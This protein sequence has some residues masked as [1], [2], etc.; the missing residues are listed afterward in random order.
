[1]PRD[2]NAE[3]VRIDELIRAKVGARVA[4]QDRLEAHVGRPGNHG[5]ADWDLAIPQVARDIEIHRAGC[6]K[7]Q[8]AADL[9]NA[10][11]FPLICK[12]SEKPASMEFRE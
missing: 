7:V 10:S 6:L 2:W 3:T 4:C 12:S 5:V 1:V 8:T 11:D 9:G